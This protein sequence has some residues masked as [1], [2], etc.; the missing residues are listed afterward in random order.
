MRF[1][2]TAAAERALAYAS[3]WRSC[4]DRDELGCV[5][6]VVGL[7]MEPECCAAIMLARVGIDIPIIQRQWPSLNE[8]S[9][10]NEGVQRQYPLSKEVE[11]SL[12]SAISQIDYLPQP[13]EIA[14]EHILLGLA[15]SDHEVGVWLRRQGVEPDA[16]A[17]EIRK[18][19]G[20]RNF[21]DVPA[22]CEGL[23]GEK[24]QEK[25]LDGDSR[26]TEQNDDSV[27]LLRRSSAEATRRPTLL[28][29]KQWHTRG[30]RSRK[31]IRSKLPRFVRSTPRPTAPARDCG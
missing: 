27:P 23:E 19:H 11:S 16:I 24:D 29:S 30:L 20:M 28:A 25:S 26:R 22:D 6:L 5:E 15:T 17:E 10:H 14:T 4:A 13:I 7:L 21:G 31:R 18:I 8:N 12:R 2:F 1:L 3:G 9:S